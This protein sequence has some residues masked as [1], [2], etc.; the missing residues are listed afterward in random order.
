MTLEIRIRDA[1]LAEAR[2]AADWYDAQRDGTG[3]DFLAAVDACIAVAARLPL[4]APLWRGDTRRRR[5]AR[6]PY[7]VFFRVRDE[8]LDVIAIAHTSRRPGYFTDR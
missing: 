4:A 1:A 7:L 5:V 8:V 3:P 2:E 6:F